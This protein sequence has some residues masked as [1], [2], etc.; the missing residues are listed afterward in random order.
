MEISAA[1]NNRVCEQYHRDHVVCPPNLR[2]GHF[3]TGAID[4]LDHNTSSITA[5]ES[6]HGTG[7][8]LF[9]HPSLHNQGHDRREHRILEQ[10]SRLLELPEFYTNV[11]PVVL[12]KKDIP[13]PNVCFTVNTDCQ[14]FHQALQEEIQ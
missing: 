14:I 13:I 7:I 4:N 1:M 3:A 10:S 11:H 5:T 6:F 2:Q 12:T 9:Q 8:S